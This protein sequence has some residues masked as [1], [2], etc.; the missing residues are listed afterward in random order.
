MFLG[1]HHS[2]GLESILEGGEGVDSNRAIR[3]C[4]QLPR[5]D[6]RMDV[7]RRV[8]RQSNSDAVCLCVHVLGRLMECVLELLRLP[9][10]EQ[11]LDLHEKVKGTLG[12]LSFQVR[13]LINNCFVP[14]LLCQKLHWDVGEWWSA[15]THDPFFSLFLHVVPVFQLLEK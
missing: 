12:C 11:P 15:V 8:R 1:L 5:T 13:W 6:E 2:C 7:L 3:L 9:G 4:F 14:H 10:T